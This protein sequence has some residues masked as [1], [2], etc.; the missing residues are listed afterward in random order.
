MEKM[1]GAVATVE[2]QAVPGEMHD[3]TKAEEEKPATDQEKAAT[4]EKQ[5]ES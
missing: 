4:E 3:P 2:E 5:T 1:E